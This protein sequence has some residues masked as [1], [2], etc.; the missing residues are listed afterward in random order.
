MGRDET[1]STGIVEG[2]KWYALFLTPKILRIIVDVAIIVCLVA[3]A[4]AMAQVYNAANA[5]MDVAIAEGL[6]PKIVKNYVLATMGL[7]LV[8]VLWMVWR[9]KRK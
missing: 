5:D 3:L 2:R 9:I 7:L 1:R 8:P 4:T 6:V